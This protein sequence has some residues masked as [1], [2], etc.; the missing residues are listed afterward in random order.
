MS[1]RHPSRPRRIDDALSQLIDSLTPPLPLSAIGDEYLDDAEEALAAAEEQKHQ[2]HLERSWRIID[3][4][5]SAANDPSSPSGVPGSL[6]LGRRGSLAGGENINN[7]SD[8]IKRKLLREN[9]S[10]DKAVRFSNLYSRLLTQPVL[11]QKWGILYLLYRLSTSDDSEGNAD[12]DGRSRSPLMDQTKLQRMLWKDQRAGRGMAELSDEDGPAASS[13]ASQIPALM[14]RKASLRRADLERERER[15][16]DHGSGSERHRMSRQHEPG[17]TKDPRGEEQLSTDRHPRD[18]EKDDNPTRPVEQGLLRDLPFNLQEPCLLYRGLST[19]VEGSGGGLVSQSLR[20]AISNE[21]RSYLGLVATLEGEIRRALAAPEESAGSKSGVTLKRCVVWTRDATMALRLMSLIVEESKN[22]KGGQLI[23]LI[24]GFSTSHGDP[25][26]CSFAEKLLTHI[27]RPFYDMLRLW[28][29]DGE[30]SDPYKEFFV[31]EPEFRPSTDPRRIATSVWEDKYKLDDDMVPSIITQDFAKKVFLIGKSLNFIRY[32]CGDSAWVEAYSK[33]ASKELRYGDTASLETSIDEAYKTTMA[34]LIH[35]MDDKFKLFD[36]LRALKKYLLLGQGDFIALLMESLASN[37]DR[38]AN[39]QYRHTLTAQLEHAIRASNAQYDSPDVLRRLDARMLELSHGEIGW[40]CF[41][42]EY[43]IDAPVDVVITPWGST[44]YLKVFNFLWRVKRVEFSLGSTWRRCMTGARGVLGSVDDKVGADWKRARCAIA[45]MIHFVCQLQYYILFEVIES[46]WDQL[47]ASISKPGCTL[48]DLIEAHTKYLNSITHKGLLGSSTSSKGSSSSSTSKPEEGF[49]S[50]LHQILKTMLAYKDAVD[51]LYSFSVAEFTRRQELNAKIET[52]TAQGQW[53]VTERDLISS[54]HGPT[55]KASASSSFS[56]TPNI[57]NVVDDMGTPSSLAGHDLSTDDQML[58]SLRVRLRDLSADFR[59]RLNMLLGDLAYQPDV[60]MRFLGVVMNF[61]EVYEPPSPPPAP[62]L[63]FMAGEKNS[64]DERA[65]KKHK[66]VK[67][68]TDGE[69]DS[70]AVKRKDKKRKEVV[71]AEAEAEVEEKENAEDGV[72]KKVKKQKRES[73]KRRL[74]EDD[75]EGGEED[76]SKEEKEVESRK[77]KKKR[78]SFA[79]DAKVE[80]G[81]EDEDKDEDEDM[82]D[83]SVVEADAEA[84]ADDESDDASK[85]EKKKQKKKEKKDK[86]KSQEGNSNG[87]TTNDASAAK[88]EAHDAPILSYLSLYHSSRS[89]WKFQKNRETQLFKYVLSLEHVPVRYNTALLSYLQGLKG[90]AAKQRLREVAGAAVKTDI[91]ETQP[92]SSNTES[93][94]DVEEPED[95]TD[96]PMVKY[97]K[98]VYAFRTD[99]AEGKSTDTTPESL[100]SDAELVKRFEKRQRAEVVLFAVDGRVFTM[101]KLKA[102][103]QKGKGTAVQSQPT[104]KKK[105]NRTAFIEISSS[106]E[107]DSNS[108]SDDGKRK[109]TKSSKSSSEPSSDSDSDSSSS[110][111]SS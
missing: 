51:G 98:A 72:N 19:F 27:T 70:S 43:K 2:E 102:P 62:R 92:E 91:E 31:V 105:K 18:P 100:V 20:A 5:S 56:Y 42:L 38:P 74:Q 13:S 63:H 77:K 15:D 108:D 55:H 88:E 106:S 65:S 33:E 11:S 34:R 95:K 17:T 53:G 90:E 57:A 41:T 14:E 85:K 99:L 47:E 101:R 40:D 78:V 64:P 104:K 36:H 61:N 109:K 16:A 1:T 68:T 80:D 111:S 82:N 79:A 21:L 60:D 26:V 54:R 39:S 7:A 52:R 73:K 32:G 75:N 107:S 35:L 76:A 46:S 50:Q 58:A 6:G 110:S 86:K 25:F 103:P 10:P 97:R 8:L 29:Y 4:H 89:A 93:T 84:E 12:D 71:E 87:S 44:Q 37:L 81:D 96:S 23:S 9:A 22:K 49:L 48:D 67:D 94:E 83:Q 3:A 66:R 28:I 59:S 45:E 24:H 30:L 69:K